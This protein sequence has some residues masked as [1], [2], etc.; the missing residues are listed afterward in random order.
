MLY[1]IAVDW[2]CFFITVRLQNEL[3]G[4]LIHTKSTNHS[5]PK[6]YLWFR[7]MVNN[8]KGVCFA[9]F[10]VCLEFWCTHLDDME[11][12]TC[13]TIFSFGFQSTLV[14]CMHY[15][16]SKYQHL[17]IFLC[18]KW[19]TAIRLKHLFIC[20][21]KLCFFSKLVFPKSSLS[22]TLYCIK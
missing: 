5:V 6:M 20:I 18:V 2:V 12:L 16:G 15:L 9:I 7:M 19:E 3:G 1:F 13:C 14:Q 17:F 4:A 11:A 10:D 22:F 21:W 8:V